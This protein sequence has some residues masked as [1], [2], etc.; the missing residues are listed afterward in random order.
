MMHAVFKALL[1]VTLHNVIALA[2]GKC[3]VQT[4]PLIFDTNA[5]C[6]TCSDSV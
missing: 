3:D 4:L 2:S 1:Q 5:R 6:L